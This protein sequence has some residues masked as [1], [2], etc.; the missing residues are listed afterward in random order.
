MRCKVDAE[1]HYARQHGVESHIAGWLAALYGGQ[2]C[3]ERRTGSW[4]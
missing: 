3:L 1:S 4:D 2:Y